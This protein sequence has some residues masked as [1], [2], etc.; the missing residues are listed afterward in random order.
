[1]AEPKPP[2]FSAF[3]LF[4]EDLPKVSHY[5]AEAHPYFRQDVL[6]IGGGNSA[7]EAALDLWRNGARVRLVH[8]EERL[9]RGIKPWVLPDITNRLERG[10]IPAHWRTRVAEIRPASVLLRSEADGVTAEVPNDWV[11]AM[12]GY[13]PD[14][15]FLRQLGVGIDPATRIPAHDP[16]TMETDVPGVFI[17]GVIAGGNRP[18][19][20]FIENGREHGPRIVAALASATG[21]RG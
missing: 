2:G 15:A 18:D 8:F 11:L 9:D 14:P 4:G 5:Y 21:S 10:E 16:A 19:R 17:A 20:I 6:V 7:V 12:T 13:C 3:H 1:V